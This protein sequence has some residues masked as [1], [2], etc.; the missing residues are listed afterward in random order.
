[1]CVGRCQNVLKSVGVVPGG[2][3]GEQD[4]DERFVDRSNLAVVSHKSLQLA[5][6]SWREV[7]ELA[8]EDREERVIQRG[9]NRGVRRVTRLIVLPGDKPDVLDTLVIV[10]DLPGVGQV[11]FDEVKLQGSQIWHGLGNCVLEE[12]VCSVDVLAEADERQVSHR[13]VALNVDRRLDTFG[14]ERRV[15]ILREL[16][17]DL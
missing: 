17:E 8:E 4:V 2:R 3:L 10:G 16:L 5:K 15:H 6:G 9:R 1:M 14:V 11:L 13:H 7:A 12:V